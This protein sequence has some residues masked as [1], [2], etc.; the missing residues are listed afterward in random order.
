MIDINLPLD[1]NDPEAPQFL[2][3]IQGNIIK[4]HG[5]DFTAHL[6]LKMT[7]SSRPSDRGLQDLRVRT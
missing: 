5:R 4:G 1:L 7:G 3:R 6:I 2:S